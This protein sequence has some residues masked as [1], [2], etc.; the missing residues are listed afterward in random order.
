MQALNAKLCGSMLEA[1]HKRWLHWEA[2]ELEPTHMQSHCSNNGPGLPPVP[3]LL[4]CTPQGM[5]PSLHAVHYNLKS[6]D[7]LIS[8]FSPGS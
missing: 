8:T 6:S 1:Y 4:P 3:L 5:Q 7:H 2:A